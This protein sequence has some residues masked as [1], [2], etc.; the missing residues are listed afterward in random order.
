MEE[1]ILSLDAGTTASKISLF[2]TRGNLISLSTQE[3]E[4]LTPTALTVE[5]SAEKFW[6]AFKL[7]TREV[8]KHSNI[9]PGS[10]KAF[11]LSAQGETL[12]IID[13]EG[14][15]LRNAISW[16]DNRA[17]EQ[18]EILSKEFPNDEVYK[19]T[20]QVSIVPTWPAAKLLWIKQNEPKIFERIEKVLLVE[21]YLIWKLT[22]QF[23][24]EGSLI[25]STVYWNITTE[26]WWDE[27]LEFLGI[28]PAQLPEIRH[29]GEVIGNIT[30]NAAREL[31]LT[32]NLIVSMGA[33]DQACGTIGVGN[34]KPGIFTENTGAALAICATQDKNTPTFDK[35]RRIP[36]HY[37]GIPKRYMFHTFT[38]GGMVLRW[39]RDKFCQEIINVAKEKGIDAYKLIDEMVREIPPGSDGLVMLPH[40][41]GAMAPEDNP[42]A[43]GVF[44]GFT[45]KHGKAHFARA[46]MEAIAFI[47]RRNLDIVEDINIKVN[48][49]RVLGGGARSD[50]WNQI[51]ADVTGKTLVRT[52]NEEAA[53]L[54]AAIFA[55]KGAGI[56]S[57][58]ED[59]ASQM[60]SIKKKYEPNNSNMKIYSNAYQKYIKLY[61]DLI[62][63]FSL[64]KS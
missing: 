61:E 42:N 24:C 15:P 7:G 9:D 39:Y 20:G 36:V 50:I 12:I 54:G 62:D 35:Q 51:K 41:Q 64:S 8:L 28:S 55:G 25:C 32:T 11:S 29:S 4:L 13:K 21:D 52:V 44:F 18:A 58:I 34:V 27:M 38:T 48:E 31:G 59:A 63:L 49:I 16:M 43:K 26:K 3:Y 46:I 40:L 5:I 56:Y 37:H 10:I 22:G 47:V 6:E 30:A 23:A 2:D 57:S 14:K 19:I 45:L 60:I 33:L 17:Q 1:Y 53:C